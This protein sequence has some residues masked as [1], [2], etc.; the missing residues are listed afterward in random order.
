MTKICSKNKKA[1]IVAFVFAFFLI[2]VGT[3]FCPTTANAQSATSSNES[4]LALTQGSAPNIQYADNKVYIGTWLTN[5]FNYDYQTST[6]TLDM[7]LYFFWTNSNITTVD[8]QFTNGYPITPT[9]ITL[10]ASDNVSSVKHEIYRATG[11]FAS[12][13][14]ASDFPFDKINIV[15]S[16]A[17]RPHGNDI[18]LDW[19]N[20]ETVVDTQ[21]ENP[22]WKTTNIGLTVSNHVYPL[23][24]EAPIANMVVT[25]ER[26]KAS[27]SI[28]PFIPSLIFSAICGISFL[29]NIKENVGPRLALIT[30]MLV[31]TLLF[32][33][34]VSSR[35]PPA[36]T[37]VFYTI[38]LLSVMLFM[39]ISLLVTIYGAVDWAK[40]QNENRLKKINKWGLIVSILIPIIF[41]VLIF[42]LRP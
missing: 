39:G 23:G 27:E 30:S 14:D 41:F 20:N 10:L 33:F 9:S 11:Q 29:F 38:F 15:V 36:S 25:Q 3:F 5:I 17:F 37:I 19:L 1:L 35:I 32:N 34:G 18:G 8:W 4:N 24:I 16:V 7:V 42:F 21:F 31:T 28:Q 2:S 40:R 6:Y 13:P 22:G 26:Q 12:A